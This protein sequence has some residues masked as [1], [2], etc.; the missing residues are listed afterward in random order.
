MIKIKNYSVYVVND[1]FAKDF[2]NQY[3]GIVVIMNQLGGFSI[4]KNHNSEV[5]YHNN[6]EV[7]HSIIFND[8]E[9]SITVNDEKNEK[10][11]SVRHLVFSENQ[12]DE[13]KLNIPYYL[14]EAG[15]YFDSTFNDD[16]L[17]LTF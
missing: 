12:Y 15:I 17:E 14:N 16:N 10:N 7:M 5:I 1:T 4:R 2:F 3:N 11:K 9:K 13:L 8:I 6:K